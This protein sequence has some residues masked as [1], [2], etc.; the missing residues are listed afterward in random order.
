MRC[1]NQILKAQAVLAR[2]SGPSLLVSRDWQRAQLIS[3][4]AAAGPQSG[5]RR[6][7]G[8]GRPGENVINFTPRSPARRP[9]P[10]APN[11]RAMRS[12]FSYAPPPPVVGGLAHHSSACR[13]SFHMRGRRVVHMRGRLGDDPSLPSAEHFVNLPEGAVGRR[14]RVG[15]NSRNAQ[16]ELALLDSPPGCPDLLGHQKCLPLLQVCECLRVCGGRRQSALPCRRRAT[17]PKQQRLC[18]RKSAL[19]VLPLGMVDGPGGPEGRPCGGGLKKPSAFLVRHL[20]V[21][22][23]R[24]V[25]R[26]PWGGTFETYKSPGNRG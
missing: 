14:R 15:M 21:D 13:R 10:T 20:R 4:L 5:A 1:Q 18:V 22:E 6:R 24:R 16:R 25:R 2:A 7:A 3:D 19:V 9:L 8:R 12:K 26:H 17:R 23:P 11:P